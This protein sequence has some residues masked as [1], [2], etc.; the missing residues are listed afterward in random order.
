[1]VV[2]HL[3]APVVH[4]LQWPRLLLGLIPAAIG[5]ALNV[6]ADRQFKKH[7]TT[8]KPFEPST[9]LVVDRVFGLSRNP[10]YV[11]MVL[12]LAGIAIGLGSLTPIVILPVFALWLDR[13]FISP[14]EPLLVAQFGEP[15]L[16]YR[17]RVRRWI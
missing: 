12:I 2:L 9:A 11:G 15:Y 6:I 5:I 8:V 1:M 10:M 14:E 17:R 16:E 7:G 4:W 3:L 13:N